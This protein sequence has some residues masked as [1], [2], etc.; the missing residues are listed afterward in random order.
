MLV[1]LNSNNHFGHLLHYLINSDHLIIMTRL[2]NLKN[3]NSDFWY[4][5]MNSGNIRAFLPN[6]AI[7]QGHKAFVEIMATAPRS[8]QGFFK[9]FFNVRMIII[10]G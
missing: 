6:R 4:F 10:A 1:D 7:W 9:M 5:A 3:R 2:F 8:F